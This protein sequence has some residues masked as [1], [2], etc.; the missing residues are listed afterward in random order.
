MR[1]IHWHAS[2]LS[3]TAT[4]RCHHKLHRIATLK[5][6]AQITMI[7]WV[8]ISHYNIGAMLVFGRG[9]HSRM[10]LV[11]TPARLKLYHVCAQ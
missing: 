2:L 5:V 7:D 11:L 6:T 8:A 4:Y 10:P 1:V 9:L 3:T